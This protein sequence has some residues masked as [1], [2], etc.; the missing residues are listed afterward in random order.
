[1]VIGGAHRSTN[2][3]LSKASSS[4]ICRS[5]LG[6]LPYASHQTYGL[7]IA[8]TF[9]PGRTTSNSPSGGSRYEVL[10][11]KRKCPAILCGAPHV[12]RLQAL[13]ASASLLLPL[14]FFNSHLVDGHTHPGFIWDK[15]K[16]IFENDWI[17]NDVVR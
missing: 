15:H 9:G 17:I 1:V 4:L 2:P 12:S 8:E 3:L 5:W 14:E 10:E 13:N 16:S 7:L 6:V 11:R